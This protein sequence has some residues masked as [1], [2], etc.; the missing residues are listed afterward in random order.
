[1]VFHVLFRP[2]LK[3]DFSLISSRRKTAGRSAKLTGPLAKKFW[4]RGLGRAFF[5][6]PSPI[7]AV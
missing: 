1:M 5:K 7:L 6:R 4:E 2:C 3:I